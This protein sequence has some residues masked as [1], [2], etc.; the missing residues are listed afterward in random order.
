LFAG[1]GLKAAGRYAGGE[2][3]GEWEWWRENGQ[4]LQAGA[5]K[6]GKQVGL[7]QRYYPKSGALKRR[8]LFKS[9]P[10]R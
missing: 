2:F 7:W 4:P 3:D 1:G 8:R 5:F 10:R 9:K 6:D